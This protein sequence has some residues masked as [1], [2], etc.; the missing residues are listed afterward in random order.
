[1]RP[2]SPA[3]EAWDVQPALA[4]GGKVLVKIADVAHG[5]VRSGVGDAPLA[6]CDLWIDNDRKKAVQA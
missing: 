2:A 6:V 5:K 1:M 3:E 4:L